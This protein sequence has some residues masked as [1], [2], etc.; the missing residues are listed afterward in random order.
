[1]LYSA[2]RL[3]FTTG[4]GPV[5]YFQWGGGIFLKHFKGT[6]TSIIPTA[7]DCVAFQRTTEH[8]TK[9]QSHIGLGGET[10]SIVILFILIPWTKTGLHGTVPISNFIIFGGRKKQSRSYARGRKGKIKSFAGRE[11]IWFEEFYGHKKKRNNMVHA[12]MMA[13]SY[14]YLCTNRGPVALAVSKHYFLSRASCLSQYLNS[15]SWHFIAI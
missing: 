13:F 2:A 11:A 4:N 9:I 14:C 5:S 15:Y 1:M 6:A 3:Y 10:K 12:L 8:Q 7:G